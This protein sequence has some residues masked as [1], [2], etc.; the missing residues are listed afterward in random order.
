MQI[1][2]RH[3]HGDVANNATQE[4]ASDSS[5]STCYSEWPSPFVFPVKA[6]SPNLVDVLG[7]HI[8]L[9]NPKQRYLRG[10]LLQTLCS[11]AVKFKTHPDHHEKVEMAKSIIVAFPH[12]KEAVGRGYDGWLASVIDCLKSTR[13]QL[14]VIDKRRSE[15]IRKRKLNET[16]LQEDHVHVV[17]SNCGPGLSEPQPLPELE[18]PAPRKRYTLTKKKKQSSAAAGSAHLISISDA[19]TQPPAEESTLDL[20]SS[21]TEPPGLSDPQPLPELQHL[22]PGNRY[23]LTKK[24]K[25]SAAAGSA[26]SISFSD[27]SAQPP[28]EESTLDLHSSTAEP[29]LKSLDVA[30]ATNA[31]R[32]MNAE[33]Q[34]PAGDRN[35]DVLLRLLSQTYEER[36]AVM[37][38]AYKT[39]LALRDEYPALFCCTGIFQEYQLVENTKFTMAQAVTNAVGAGNS[40]LKLVESELSANRANVKNRLLMNAV[41][42]KLQL[43]LEDSDDDDDLHDQFRGAAGFLLLPMLLGESSSYFCV[44]YEVTVHCN[45][46]K[47]KTLGATMHFYDNARK[48]TFLLLVS[49]VMQMLIRLGSAAHFANSMKN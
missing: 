47:V 6:L 38:T 41:L 40:I 18:H 9:C 24:K 11:E 2:S 35:Y 1:Q 23:T 15:A 45:S 3:S 22:A 7:K 32:C 25:Q 34:K 39:T 37:H 48:E 12:L 5:A 14:G 36:R 30:T 27:A 13:R 10:L 16:E 8:N 4:V 49:C 17:A 28:A 44:E 20:H 31:L 29:H 42:T 46:R 19:S 21:T 26:E 33:W 43:S